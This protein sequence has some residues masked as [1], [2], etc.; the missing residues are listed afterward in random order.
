MEEEKINSK[1]GVYSSY[2]AEVKD[3]KTEF[4][5]ISERVIGKPLTQVMVEELYNKYDELFKEFELQDLQ[6]TIKLDEY[7]HMINFNPIRN[8]DKLAIKGI[9]SL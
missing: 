8:I 2:K 1:P 6:F 5:A 4:N 9:L 3:L 7:E